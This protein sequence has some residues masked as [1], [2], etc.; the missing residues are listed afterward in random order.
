M[1][2]LRMIVL[3]D[4]FNTTCFYDIVLGGTKVL[5]IDFNKILLLLFVANFDTFPYRHSVNP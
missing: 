3:Q 4:F 1:S 2:D 5:S